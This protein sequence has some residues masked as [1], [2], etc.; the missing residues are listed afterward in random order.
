MPTNFELIHLVVVKGDQF[1]N[2]RMKFF[3]K[4]ITASCLLYSRTEAEKV[5]LEAGEGCTLE[6][7]SCIYGPGGMECKVIQS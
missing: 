3:V 5:L 6:T 4:C 7:I 1:Y 2:H